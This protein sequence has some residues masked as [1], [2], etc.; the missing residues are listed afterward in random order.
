MIPA[1][2]EK[3][4]RMK[5][6]QEEY[7]RLCGKSYNKEYLDFVYVDEMGDRVKPD[8]I[9]TAFQA[10]LKKRDLKRVRFHDLRHSYVKPPLKKSK[11]SVISESAAT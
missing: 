10:V 1:L 3:L 5:T 8:Y 11:T 6:E 2:S 9:S 4:L 7:R